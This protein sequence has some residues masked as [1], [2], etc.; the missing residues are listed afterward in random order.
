MLRFDFK[1]SYYLYSLM[2]AKL[3]ITLKWYVFQKLSLYI[4]D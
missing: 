3:V 4:C 1:L 2:K